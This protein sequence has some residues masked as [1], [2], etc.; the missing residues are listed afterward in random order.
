MNRRGFTLVELVAVLAIMSLLAVFTERMFS[1][2]LRESRTR[3]SGRLLRD[4]A[5][6]V[7]EERAGEE[8]RGFLVDTGRGVRASDGADGRLTLSELWIRPDDTAEYALRP[9]TA[10]NLAVPES[11]KA[12]LA[13]PAVL[14]PCGWRGPYIAPRDGSSRLRDAWGNPFETPDAASFARLRDAESNA[15]ARAGT[16]IR[17]VSHLGSDGRDDAFAAPSS[18]DARDGTAALSPRGTRASLALDVHFY[19]ADGIEALN[20]YEVRHYSA[21]GGAITGGVASAEA[22]APLVLRDLPVGPCF[23][24]ITSGDGAFTSSVQRVF[25]RPGANG[26]AGFRFRK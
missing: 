25:V 22:S 1:K 9:A 23:I 10:E 18:A 7:Y 19:D 16:E 21:C 2:T 12:R 14:V 8:P 4:I 24:R 11:E 5:A 13:D 26:H 15:V 20:S 17:Y 6:A 3:L